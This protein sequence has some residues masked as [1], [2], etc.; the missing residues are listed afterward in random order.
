MAEWLLCTPPQQ[1]GQLASRSY[2]SHPVR[3]VLTLHHSQAASVPP[4][5]PVVPPSGPDPPL[6]PTIGLP[7]THTG[8]VVEVLELLLHQPGVSRLLFRVSPS[9]IL[10]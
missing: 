2:P 7:V 10:H 3:R 5:G 8:G 9:A 4:V 1:V 6:S